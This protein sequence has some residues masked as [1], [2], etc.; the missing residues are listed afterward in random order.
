MNC[1]GPKG[2]T[3]LIVLALLSITLALSYAMMRSQFT[4]AQIQLNY[5][6]RSDARLAAYA[7]ISLAL[8]KM[9][10]SNWAGV[11]VPLAKDL[12]G[13]QSFVVRFETG[14]SSLQPTDPYYAEY[15]YRV[16]MTST[17]TVTDPVTSVVT[18]THTVRSTVQFVRRALSEPP[19]SW[20]GLQNYTLYQWG[21]GP[22]D[23]VELDLP[24]RIEGPLFAQNEI[25]L[26]VNYPGDG[27]DVP[28]AGQI[29]E[30]VVFQQPLTSQQIQNLANRV[31]TLSSLTSDTSLQPIARWRFDEP[32]GS[33][34]A[35]DD[36]EV[37]DGLYDGAT[38]GGTPAPYVGGAGSATFDGFNDQI[39]LDEVRVAGK[40]I[41]ILAWFKPSAF[42][43]TNGRIISKA[44]GLSDTEHYWMLST[45]Q[46]GSNFRLRFLVQTNQNGSQ[47]LTASA[48]NLAVGTWVF[49]AAVYD[50]A[51]MRLYK[52]GVL[53]GSKTMSGD[54]RNVHT[55][56][57]SIGNNPPG[58]PRAQL[59]R[60]WNRMRLLGVDYRP[61][62]GP[63][64]A[65][66]A[67]TPAKTQSLF[68][69]E[70]QVTWNNVGTNNSPPLT[71][72]GAVL[73]YQL[74]PGGKVYD[75]RVLPGTLQNVTLQ[76]D[77][78]TNPL[79]V[80][81]RLGNLDVR[82]NVNV[83]G[84]L[85]VNAALTEPDIEIYGNNVVFNPIS[86]PWLDGSAQGVQLPMA[87][88]KDDFRIYDTARG[89]VNGLV[90]AW[91]ECGFKSGSQTM[92]FTINGKLIVNQFYAEPRTQ[93]A[94]TS[95]W[96]KDQTTAYLD[97]LSYGFPILFFPSWLQ[98]FHKLDPVPH[99]IIRPDASN[100]AYHWP[101][102]TEP[103]FV[104]HPADGGLRW[105]VL[106]IREIP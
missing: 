106:D 39:H 23:L 92:A 44:K 101:L 31:I 6:R 84:V 76:P 80:Y 24:V 100:P 79:G 43:S 99:L 57:V 46:S 83:T 38:A 26:G 72:P 28:F 93:W 67:L 11:T 41:T 7:G 25:K 63:I 9:Q 18:S 48:G 56:P 36:F 13:G 40:D 37:S 53:V 5:Q 55:L 87:I 3:V 17:G 42:S 64:N 8:R 60:G 103:I 21:R 70:L 82:D 29:D 105:E 81:Y 78:L 104:A 45:C 14:D 90:A 97:S 33:F 73:K 96:W 52:D 102:W 54:L 91:D 22:D 89:T 98:T 1:R 88:V 95:S 65:P 86:L 27:D 32:S 47:T 16:T 62:T 66:R 59:L 49:A 12:G 4:S 74:Y 94:Q 68:E 77:P 30:V 69:D 75:C 34:I 85:I 19:G 2:V 10:E 51:T 71:H 61:V 15:P 50:G 58:S 35:R 20:S